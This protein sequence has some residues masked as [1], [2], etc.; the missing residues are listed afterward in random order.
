M[1]AASRSGSHALPHGSTVA[2]TGRLDT[3]DARIRPATGEP[4]CDATVPCHVE[5]TFADALAALR[6]LSSSGRRRGRRIGDQRQTRGLLQTFPTLLH[7]QRQIACPSGP[8]SRSR[9]ATGDLSAQRLGKHCEHVAVRAD[10]LDDEPAAR[11]E[12]GWS[13]PVHARSAATQWTKASAERAAI[14]R[15]AGGVG[16]GEKRRGVVIDLDAFAVDYEE[17]A[18]AREQRL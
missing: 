2:R 1:G 13:D 8:R 4:R 14:G 17:V 18:C 11:V 9:R 6:L 5:R 15:D 16:R 10:I 7:W 3:T 12:V